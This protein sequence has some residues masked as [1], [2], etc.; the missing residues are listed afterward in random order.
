MLSCSDQHEQEQVKPAAVLSPI[1]MNKCIV[2]FV[3][4]QAWRTT[5]TLS[6]IHHRDIED[7]NST[8]KFPGKLLP[9]CSAHTRY[10][11]LARLS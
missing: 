5:E 9:G 8:I 11:S 7:N 3:P 1:G 4:A 2:G 6:K 10:L